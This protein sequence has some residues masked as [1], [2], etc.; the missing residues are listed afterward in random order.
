[1]DWKSGSP[2]GMTERKGK[3]PPATYL[4]DENWVEESWVGSYTSFVIS[5]EAK[6][7]GEICGFPFR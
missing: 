2:S 4:G 6:W 3:D 1:M 5:T 7:S